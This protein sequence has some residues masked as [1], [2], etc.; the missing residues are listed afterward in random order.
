MNVSLTRRTYAPNTSYICP[1]TFLFHLF[2]LLEFLFCLLGKQYVLDRHREQN[3]TACVK[4][5]NDQ[6]HG[7]PFCCQYILSVTSSVLCHTAHLWLVVCPT[8]SRLYGRCFPCRCVCGS[9]GV[10]SEISA[11]IYVRAVV[12]QLV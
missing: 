12:G 2:P 7:C 3:I 6:R 11:C 1:P 9:K 5:Q 4:K 8:H 10:L